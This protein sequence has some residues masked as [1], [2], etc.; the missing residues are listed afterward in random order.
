MYEFKNINFELCLMNMYN[1][2]KM[3]KNKIVENHYILYNTI[4]ISVNTINFRYLKEIIKIIYFRMYTDVL[5]ES[6]YN[7]ICTFI[8]VYGQW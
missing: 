6:L 7:I 8:N 3:C 5:C 4:F 2:H 1:I